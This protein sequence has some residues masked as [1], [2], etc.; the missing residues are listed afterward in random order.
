[1]KQFKK[2]LV[3]ID[4][5][6][7]DRFVGEELSAPNAEALRR[8]LWLANENNAEVTLL[9]A[10]DLSEKAQTLLKEE[11]GLESNVLVDAKRVLSKLEQRSLSTGVKVHSNV[12]IGKS[13]MEIIRLVQ[14]DCFDLVVVGTRHLGPTEGFPPWQHWYQTTEKLPLSSLGHDANRWRNL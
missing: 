2:I 11:Q 1:M 5:S 3:G 10:L 13:W 9:Y 12:V 4:L 6:Y 8:A 14:H 7:G